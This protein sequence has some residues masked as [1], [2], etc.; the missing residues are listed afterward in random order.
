MTVKKE[1]GNLLPMIVTEGVTVKILPNEQYEY[2]MTTREVAHGY[3]TSDY[4]VRKTMLRHEVELSEGK[5]YV[6]GVS[7]LPTPCN[8][9]DKMSNPLIIQPHQIFWTKRGI[10]RLGFFIKSERAKF[11]RDWAEE[12]VIQRVEQYPT[13]FEA[14]SKRLPKKRR[15]NR[16]SQ[17]RL[18]NILADVC[19]IEDNQ[20]RMSITNKLMGGFEYGNSVALSGQKG[21][22]L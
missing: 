22:G 11:F 6:K 5:H 7:V 12:L 3:G 2:L 15:C 18:V 14:P 10:V 9:V 19:R 1:A 16:L 8:G 20:L 17:E 21:G 13:L 4:V